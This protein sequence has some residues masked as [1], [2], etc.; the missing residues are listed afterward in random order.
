MKGFIIE[1]SEDQFYTSHSG[2]ALIGL[3][4]NRYTRLAKLLAGVSKL[5]KGAI[6]HADVVR[7]YLGL[8]CLGKSD[9]AAIEGFRQDRF[10]RE[11]LGLAEVPSE[12]TLR[13]RL[14]QHG[15]TFHPIVNGCVS[16]FLQKSGALFSALTT[17]HVPLDIDVA[18]MD[19]SGTKK[20]GVSRTY[21]RFDGFAPIAAYLALEGWLLEIE[22]REGSQH[23]Q[24]NFI[25][26]LARVV[27]K[28]LNLTTA[29]LLVRLDS[30]H[31]AW[32]TRIELAG[33]ERVDYIL[34]WSPRGQGKALWHR[35]A[36]AEGKIS[37]PRP[38]KRVALLS[39][40]DTH[41][42]TD[43]TGAKRELTCRRVVRVTE[44]TIDKK[45]QLLLEPD[46]ELEGWWSSLKLP[47][48]KIISLYEDHGT[49]E[50]FHSELKTDMDLERLPSEK[51]EVNSL[52]MACAALSY[53]ILRFIGQ[54][55]LL[56]DKTPVRHPAK[57]RRLKT[58]IPELMYLAA[59]LIETGRRFR[60]RFSRHSGLSLEAF[61]GLYQRLAAG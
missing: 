18:T 11:A 3:C 57:R 9:F 45:G 21:Q 32:E 60:L 8:L 58:V 16:E 24:K 49:S 25:P 6:V 29:P 2:A 39:A 54:L 61:V 55:G 51:F 26:F 31:D 42:W 44:R 10:F 22:H 14:E 41:Q 34:K 27:R 15:Q 5:K 20:Q 59:R 40:R 30:A 17:G 23:S 35:R 53:N 12:P 43:E 37:E 36:F 28:A 48:E 19:N 38:G 13:Q 52:I 46:F 1:K 7:S 56:G 50:Q 4:L 47:V 33:R